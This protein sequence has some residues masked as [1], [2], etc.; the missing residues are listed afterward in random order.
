MAINFDSLP[1]EKSFGIEPG[2]YAGTIKSAEMRT[3]S[4]ASS[5]GNPYLSAKVE[6]DNGKLVFINLFEPSKEFLA[7]QLGRFLNAIGVELKGQGELKDLIKVIIGKR[8][9]LQLVNNDRG[10]PTVDFTGSSEGYYPV[11]QAAPKEAADKDP[12]A[13]LTEDTELPDDFLL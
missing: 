9:E 2:R 11:A 4:S 6:L 13:A 10:Y 5:T 3:P 8:L 12:A 1:T 7:F